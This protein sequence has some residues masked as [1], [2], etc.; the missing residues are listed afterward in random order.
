LARKIIA[1]FDAVDGP[2]I[3]KLR[4]IDRSINNF[5]R[6][7]LTAFG[8][9]EKGMN[10]LLASASRLQSLSGLIAGGLGVNMATRFIDQAARIRNALRAAGDDSDEMF[11][12][13]FQASTRSLAGFET[14]AQGVQRLQKAMDGKQ[15]LDRTIRQL[16]TLNK[17]MLLGGKTGSERMSTMTQFTQAVQ[18]GVLQG[19]EL[20]S[21]RENAPIELMRAIADEAGGTIEDLKALGEAGKLTTDVMIRALDRLEKE[22]DARL[23][24][25]Q[26]TMADAATVMANG[27]LVAA[28][29][30][31][32]G[33]GLSRT[34]VAGLK[35]LG[36]VLGENA[37]AAE[38]FGRALREY[39]IPFL[40]V[41]YG[42]RRINEA[43]SGLKSYSQ[44]LR[45][46]A[47]AAAKN[48]ADARNSFNVAK[49]ALSQ[50]QA[51][52]SSFM[53][54]ADG[55]IKAERDSATASAKA[56]VVEKQ[57]AEAKLASANIASKSVAAEVAAIEKKIA[58]E[59]R[60]RSLGFTGQDQRELYGDQAYT[61]R[62]G[63][64]NETEFQQMLAR[65][66]ALVAASK[67]AKE[68]QI[69]AEKA[70][71]AAVASEAAARSKLDVAGIQA[72]T[73]FD[74]A[75]KAER[76]RLA[77][78]LAAAEAR[79]QTATE[80]RAAAEHAAAV[81]TGRLSLATRATAAAG[82]LLWGAYAF[83]GGWP[84]MILLAATAFL[85]LRAN[86]ESAAERFERLTTDTGTAEAAA[87][88]LKDV[89]AR[90]NEA[91]AAAGTA[92]DEASR[93]IIANTQA[94]LRAKATLLQFEKDK[95]V[96][97][98]V[99]RQQEIAALRQR[100][101]AIREQEAQALAEI[102]AMEIIDPETG[103]QMRAAFAPLKEDIEAIN[104]QISQ[105]EANMVI[106]SG[107][108]ESM[109]SAIALAYGDALFK[110]EGLVDS[111][112]HLTD[113]LRDAWN[114]AQGIA[115]TNMAGAIDPAATAAER[116][117]ARLA[118]AWAWLRTIIGM[119]PVGGGVKVDDPA[120]LAYQYS[121]YGQ[122]RVAGERLVRDAGGLYGGTG[123]VLPPGY[124]DV[125]GSG[126]GGSKGR[127]AEEEAL[128][129]IEQMMTAEERRAQQMQEMIALREK[130]IAT[131][132]PE[133][134]IVGQMDDAIQRL[135]ESMDEVGESTKTMKEGLIDAL[136]EGKDLGDILNV[137][138]QQARKAFAQML[139]FN[140]GPW[141]SGGGKGLFGGITGWIGG[142]L[143]F[144]DGGIMTGSGSV[145]LR[146]YR[147]GGVARSAQVA[148]YGEGDTAE[149][150]VP[151]P[152]GRSIPVT[153]SLPKSES[154]GGVRY[155]EVPYIARV[156]TDDRGRLVSRI[157][158]ARREAVVRDA[159]TAKR[160]MSSMPDLI[161]NTQSRGTT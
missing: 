115:G 53:R 127:T 117:V 160:V 11:K 8:R 64:A 135:K 119:A 20:R 19:D 139:L 113:G 110:S 85:T 142:I 17:L 128:R 92:S 36:D 97:L 75:S 24:N 143:G 5:E 26:I 124:Y 43:V 7:T 161:R 78:D 154:F 76:K 73:N 99:E 82:R 71:T 133:A 13:V 55:Y 114:S 120:G 54:R 125:G 130:L 101:A 30:F 150:Y 23:K 158:D 6:G 67:T 74:K 136:A 155:V 111:I 80:R 108:I 49:D 33:L 109:G 98:Q 118:R 83:L 89:Q 22:A 46:A 32:K 44:G 126:G 56:A 59:T 151:L 68:Q 145:P 25:V 12:K 4:A 28:E 45:D 47:A 95:L 70:L 3:N 57:A 51:A 157:E 88:S 123:N 15:S 65:R 137:L 105:L 86:V 61:R 87:A 91:I 40:A 52:M 41:S 29:A 131:Y 38:M 79:L 121:Q 140:E 147:R 10:G 84:G 63:G 9:V 122:G 159:A 72:V 152:D 148:V 14:F 103:K 69:L 116:L 93:K 18:A 77:N 144:A 48:A 39:V 134:E 16:E 102:E 58:A 21:L 106:T 37:E 149:A 81:A 2:F 35:A 104:D 141:A 60:L 100:A 153:L 42:G 138:A 156:D 107:Q 146:K 112:W 90:L 27:A 129:F 96:A 62:I 50:R 31:D 1:E 34:T 94:E 132:G 66:D